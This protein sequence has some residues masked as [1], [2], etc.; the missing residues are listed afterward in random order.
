M[1][2]AGLIFGWNSRRFLSISDPLSFDISF[3]ITRSSSRTSALYCHFIGIVR[4]DNHLCNRINVQRIRLQPKRNT[5]T[6][7]HSFTSPKKEKRTKKMN[8]LILVVYMVH[9]AMVFNQ[10]SKS[11]D[12]F[13][14]QIRIYRIYDKAFNPLVQNNTATEY[15]AK[16][17]CCENVIHLT[18]IHFDTAT[19][20]FMT[21]GC[22]AFNAL[23]CYF[24]L[25]FLL[26]FASSHTMAYN[27]TQQQTKWC[28][29]QRH[30]SV[31]IIYK[32]IPIETNRRSS[33]LRT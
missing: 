7:T 28:S 18:S 20:Y 3:S 15:K 2:S 27:K 24:Y 9:I 25:T 22:I 10:S 13:I 21:M 1:H 19:I 5:H 11:I 6:H 12:W 30:K 14:Y 33:V 29:I 8:Y 23:V 26:S 4:E 32:P 16:I 17:Y 31:G